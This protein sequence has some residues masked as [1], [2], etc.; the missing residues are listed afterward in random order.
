MSSVTNTSPRHAVLTARQTSCE[1][2][3]LTLEF[4]GGAEQL[5]GKVQVHRVKLPQLV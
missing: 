4:N 2:L 1:P 3:M 5:V